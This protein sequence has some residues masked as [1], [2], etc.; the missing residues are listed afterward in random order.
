MK[1]LDSRYDKE[2]ML[3]FARRW[4][5]DDNLIYKKAAE[6]QMCFVRD[7]ICERL[8]NVPCFKL[9]WHTSKSCLLPVYGFV[10]RNGVKVICRNNFYDWKLS[11][12]VPAPLTMDFIPEDILT[13]YSDDDRRKDIPD[14]YLEGF[15]EEWAWPM[16][17]PKSL[18][19]TRFT[20]E[21]GDDYQ[22][23]MLMFMLNKAFPEKTYNDARTK[24]EIADS[25]R[26]IYAVNGFDD[27]EED[28]GKRRKVMK[29]YEILFFTWC[30]I[31]KCYEEE[32]N[33]SYLDTD[34]MNDPDVVAIYISDHPDVMNVFLMEE[35]MFGTNFKYD[36][37]D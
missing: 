17:D 11:I 26:A 23:Y 19:Q 14:C 32:H 5:L 20:I 3:Y 29:G 9:S 34:F 21:I 15:K 33:N 7:R 36:E 12:E 1:P 27:Y 37:L 10:M 2:H 30:A 35:Y 13:W 25:I 8:L 24:D 28:D 18:E 6:K 31:R 4:D 22:F 16:Y